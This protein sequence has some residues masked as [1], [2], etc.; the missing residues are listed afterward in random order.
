MKFEN[1]ITR[2]LLFESKTATDSSSDWNLEHASSYAGCKIENNIYLF[3]YFT[4]FQVLSFTGTLV[5]WEGIS[6]K[7]YTYIT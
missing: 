1:E 2:Y 6:V 7:M 4:D 5:N 3:L